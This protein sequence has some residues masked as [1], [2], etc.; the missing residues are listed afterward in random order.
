MG[1]TIDLQEF[2]DRLDSFKASKYTVTRTLVLYAA[3]L[4]IA[5]EPTMT[6]A[7][8]L[9]QRQSIERSLFYEIVLQSYLFLGFPRMLI[10]SDHLNRTMPAEKRRSELEMVSEQESK[11]WYVNGLALCRKIYGSAFDALRTRV[12][13]VS[14]EIFRWMIIEGYGK[15]LSRPGLGLIERELV[16]VAFLMIENRDQQLHSHMR[17]SLNVGAT[18]ELLSAVVGD[19]GTVAGGGHETA[20]EIL[21]KLGCA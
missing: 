19:I 20:R 9:G 17:G 3:T 1:T 14:P 10:A 13:G 8:H 5:D 15:V 11:H 16:N 6:S 4:A 18:P 2:R 21:V 7:V 12:E